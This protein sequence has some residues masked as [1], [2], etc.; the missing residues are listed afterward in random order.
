M[1]YSIFY[2]RIYFY[3]FVCLNYSNTQNI[4]KFIKLESYGILIF[5]QITKF[6]KFDKNAWNFL[7]WKFSEFSEFQIFGIS[8]IDNF[9]DFPNSKF[10]EFS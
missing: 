9:G 2:F 10:L 8:Q 3:F 7:N 6:Y 4:C 1:S 5:S